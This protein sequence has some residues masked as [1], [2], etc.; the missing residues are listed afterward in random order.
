MEREQRERAAA[1]AAQ[2]P[3]PQRSASWGTIEA[4]EEA[5]S[6]A[7][8]TT[9]AREDAVRRRLSGDGS[10]T[11][12]AR[13]DAVRRAVVAENAR[14]RELEQ[15]RAERAASGGEVSSPTPRVGRRSVFEIMED[16]ALPVQL[17]EAHSFG[18]VVQ[19]K[20]PAEEASARK[21]APPEPAA[22]GGSDGGLSGGVGGGGANALAATTIQACARGMSVRNEIL[23]GYGYGYDDDDEIFD[24][25]YS[26]QEQAAAY[27]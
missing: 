9:R 24:E 20:R 21:P 17:T 8:P 12:R 27:G 14:L 26:E 19:A 11:T 23:Y 2:Q 1:A 4:A 15:A 7:S 18:H 6:G 3:R 13:E 5:L 22:V 10:P 25:Y 16:A